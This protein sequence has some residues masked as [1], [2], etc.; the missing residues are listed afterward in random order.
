M[1]LNKST[2]QFMKSCTFLTGGDVAPDRKSSRNLLGK[3]AELFKKADYSFVN[4]EHNLSTSGTLMKG[5]PTHHR[6]NPKLIEGFIEAVLTHLSL[7][8]II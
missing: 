1:K 7:P 3:T 4:L 6:G 5:K 2:R 8:I